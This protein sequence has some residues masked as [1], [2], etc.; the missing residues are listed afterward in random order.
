MTPSLAKMLVSPD[1]RGI[2]E[3][4]LA[5][6]SEVLQAQGAAVL[7]HQNGRVLA[8]VS[9]RVDLDR[10][11]EARTAWEKGRTDL[12]SG[13]P[14]LCGENSALIPLLIGGVLVGA[15]LLDSP[16]SID[17]GEIAVPLAAAVAAPPTPQRG[18]EQALQDMSTEE[19]EREK[20]LL[21]L[22]QNEWNVSRVSR[23]MGC[24]RRTIYTHLEKWGIPRVKL[25]KG[26]LT[27]EMA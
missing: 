4:L 2:A 13:Q 21:L 15:V 25:R 3:K 8:F 14:V 5:H 19:L 7:Q 9:D 20:T 1:P 26:R 24:S 27:E 22:R 17:L 16:Q 11:S 23:L 12:E 6:L 18:L 10:L